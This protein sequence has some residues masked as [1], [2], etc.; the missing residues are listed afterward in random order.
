MNA[1]DEEDTTRLT[2]ADRMR[3]VIKNKE[4]GNELF[5]GGNFR[6]A[7]ARYHKA[8]SHSAKFFDM[9]EEDKK[10]ISALKL[11]L[12]LN[13]TSCYLKLELWDQAIRNADDALVIEPENPKAYFR[14]SAAH[15]GKKDWDKALVDIKDAQKYTLTNDKAISIAADRVKK[16]IQKH[17][18]KEKK[19]WGKAFA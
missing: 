6:P 1:G 19:T 9:N 17:K 10:E 4:E 5:K 16:E 11:S 2:K 7:A 18:E 8:L 13:L 12:Y 3:L 15:E 14:R